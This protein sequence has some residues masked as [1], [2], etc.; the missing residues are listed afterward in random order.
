[1]DGIVTSI[2]APTREVPATDADRPRMTVLT[3]GRMLLPDGAVEPADLI[4]RDGR[5]VSIESRA[6][7]VDGADVV[8]VAGR[9]ILPGTINAH[10]HSFA[11]VSRDAIAGDR[12]EAWLP[13]SIASAGGGAEAAR[14]AAALQA[15]DALRHGVTTILDHA[16]LEPE[17]VAA[18][19]DGYRSVGARLVLAAQVGDVA[20]ADSLHGLSDSARDSIRAV[21]T[22]GVASTASQIAVCEAMLD[23]TRGVRGVSALLG[24]STPERCTP[25]L[26]EQIAGLADASGAGIHVHAL[27]STQQ[28]DG[29]GSLD[30]LD[31]A[32]LL[33]PR[34][35]IA[36]AVHLSDRDVDL[37]ART[38]TSVVHNPLS[39]LFLG[40]GRQ[41][42]RRLLDARITVGLGCDGWTS[43][44]AQDVIA[45]AR[46]AMVLRRPESAPQD[47]LSPS[48]VWTAAT[49]GAAAAVGLGDAVGALRPG[50]HADLL[51]VDPARA[52][53]VD[54]IDI[55]DQIVVGGFASAVDEVWVG[56]EAV[57]CDGRSL[58]VD[59]GALTDEAARLS[60]DI[61]RGTQER[62]RVADRISAVTSAHLIS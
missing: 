39:N 26:L 24:P 53:F 57:M 46:L 59:I 35:S 50:A 56:G 52:G 27:E 22:R 21:D 25:R 11:Q 14:V 49:R 28:R 34:T 61:R 48:S 47:W 45:Q 20:F 54:G 6:V 10:T 42:L 32:G 4:I 41:D 3:G 29:G 58:R 2:N 33:G 37:L 31:N 23:I 62:R 15:L 51:I 55:V 43:G 9:L 18:V 1:M 5:I 13:L 19:V 12:L 44:G 40:A 16:A 8:D 38:Q 36:H 7:L 17:T 30:R 60:R